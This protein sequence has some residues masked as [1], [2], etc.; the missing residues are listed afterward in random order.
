MVEA[1]EEWRRTFDYEMVLLYFAV[2]LDG[3]GSG[4]TRC[5]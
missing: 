5:P 3:M 4:G 2:L 1:N